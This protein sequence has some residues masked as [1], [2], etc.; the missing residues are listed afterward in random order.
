M[1]NEI[2]IS[3]SILSTHHG[4]NEGRHYTPV[5][6]KC[7]RRGCRAYFKRLEATV[8]HA[9]TNVDKMPPADVSTA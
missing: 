8:Y 5:H 6:W 4:K 3:S 2:L 9:D 1:R 7:D